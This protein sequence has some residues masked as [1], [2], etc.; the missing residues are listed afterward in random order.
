MIVAFLLFALSVLSPYEHE[1]Y[2]R[3]VITINFLS[4][5]ECKVAIDD[6]CIGA[7]DKVQEALAPVAC[8]IRATM[9]GIYIEK[10][11]VQFEDNCEGDCDIVK[12]HLRTIFCRENIV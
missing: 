11:E 5:G 10:C 4:V 7:C 9:R 2:L 8:S 12:E 6:N 3:N 1:W